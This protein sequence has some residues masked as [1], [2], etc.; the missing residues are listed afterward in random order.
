MAALEK[1]SSTSTSVSTENDIL[2]YVCVHCSTP[3]AALYRRLSVS[4]SSIKAMT[5]YNCGKV[6]DPYME[7][8]PLL[9]AIDCILSRAEAYRHVLYNADEL[10]ALPPLTMVQFLLG[11]CVLDAYLRW[12]AEKTE[13]RG[14]VDP[15]EEEQYNLLVQLAP[16]GLSSLMGLLFQWYV[17]QYFQTKK[18]RATG[19]RIKLFWAVFLP[20]SFTA[21]TIFVSIWEN[22][23]T[24]RMLGTLLI[25]YWQ[26]TATWVVTKNLSTP[27]LC[28]LAGVLW[29]FL[30]PLLFPG[31]IACVG[32]ELELFHQRF[33]VT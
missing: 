13:F 6:V 9:V 32:Y 29:R 30:L 25:S 12:Q 7:Q 20:C 33:C 16:F 8:E 24:V 2:P 22:T 27:T 31:R 19:S 15:F 3:C 21:V 18:E 1:P 10:K 4:L 11:W 26:G 23:R 14:A 5:C 17:I 28:L